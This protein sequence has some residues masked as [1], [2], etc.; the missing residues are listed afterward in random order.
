M[1]NEIRRLKQLEVVSRRLKSIFADLSLDREILQSVSD[2]SSDACSASWVDH[3]RHERNQSIRRACEP[4]TVDRPV[5]PPFL[6]R[7][8]PR[9]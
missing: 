2:A 9:D 6:V 3:V 8:F 1:P 4:L 7:I 5:I